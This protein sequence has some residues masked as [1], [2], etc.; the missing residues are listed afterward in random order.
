MLLVHANEV[1]S[2]DV[3]M[4]VLRSSVAPD[5]ARHALH[6]QV[7]RLRARVEPSVHASER[8]LSWEASGYRL[9]ATADDL[10][11]LAFEALSRHCRDPL[12]AR[13]W[14]A[15]ADAAERALALWRGP[16]FADFSDEQFAEARAAQLEEQRLLATDYGIDARLALGQHGALVTELEDLV[17]RYPLREPLWGQLIPAL[18]P[19]RHPG[20]AEALMATP[21]FNRSYMPIC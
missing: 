5:T 15:A 16:A 18:C 14:R 12:A 2:A 7:T 13:D 4:S 19:P 20:R 10:D 17:A 8:R 3:L 21:D 6:S 9:R 1:V 11:A